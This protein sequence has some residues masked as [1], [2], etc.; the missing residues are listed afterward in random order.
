MS[1]LTQNPQLPLL[2]FMDPNLRN[3]G[4]GIK[5]AYVDLSSGFIIILK[6]LIPQNPLQKQRR[7][8]YA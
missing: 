7:T 5:S 1:V 4:A 3:S 8:C 2:F 6:V